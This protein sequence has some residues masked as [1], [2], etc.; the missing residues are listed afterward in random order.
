MLG[1]ANA[2]GCTSLHCSGPGMRMCYSGNDESRKGMMGERRGELTVPPAREV[3]IIYDIQALGV[4][5]TV[6]ERDS[7]IDII[8]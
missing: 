6:Q 4:T 2:P 8:T 1:C 7:T 5:E 3:I